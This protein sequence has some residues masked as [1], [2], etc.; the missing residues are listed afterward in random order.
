[1]MT[2]EQFRA[3]AVDCNDIDAAIADARWDEEEAPARGKIYLGCLYIER[4][5]VAGWANAATEEWHLIL[6]NCE[7]LSDDLAELEAKLYEFACDEGYCDEEA[8]QP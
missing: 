5:P 1:M 6:G 3:T 4:R 2:L 7:W 8:A